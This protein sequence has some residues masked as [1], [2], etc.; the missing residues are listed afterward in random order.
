L[1]L[2][3]I[4]DDTGSQSRTIIE[5]RRRYENAASHFQD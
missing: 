1:S 5:Y 4:I 2:I 3:F